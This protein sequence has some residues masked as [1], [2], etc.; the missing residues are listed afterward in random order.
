MI[1][2]IQFFTIATESRHEKLFR[3]TEIILF[4]SF[5]FVSADKLF[6]YSVQ[7]IVGET[8]V[9]VIVEDSHER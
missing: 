6:D 8:E 7:S 4:V 3:R 9:L 2:S 5:P 1:F